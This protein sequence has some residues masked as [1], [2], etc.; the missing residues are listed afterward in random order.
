MKQ[1]KPTKE[2]YALFDFMHEY[3]NRE[4]FGNAL[5]SVMITVT[6]KNSMGYYSPERWIKETK[7]SSDEIAIN[8]TYFNQ[9]P[10]IEILQ[11]MVHE[12]CHQW[13][14]HHGKP[15][16]N[17]HNKEFAN[18]MTS[19][20]LMPSDTGKEGGAKTGPTMAD[21]PIESGL[22]VKAA[23]KFTK[24]DKFKLLWFDRISS[25]TNN[26]ERN[27]LYNDLNLAPELLQISNNSTTVAVPSKP[28]PSKS[29]EKYTCPACNINIWGKEDLNIICGDCGN[30]FEMIIK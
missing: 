23:N 22:F 9:F 14:H 17:Y 30:N 8:P 24:E 1:I 15:S 18:K 19:I 16:V 4:L 13:Q 26:T 20:G 2:F 7:I 5:K 28:K 12:M 10:L 21:Y 11:T 25:I 3:F 6:R 29:K 27:D